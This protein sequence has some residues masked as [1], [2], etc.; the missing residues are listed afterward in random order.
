MKDIC[1]LTTNILINNMNALRTRVFDI[2][3]LII[4]YNYLII[5]NNYST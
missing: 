5:E 2:I 4:P 3:N 1:G